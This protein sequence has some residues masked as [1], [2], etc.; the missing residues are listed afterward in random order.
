[1][2]RLGEN[3]F[4]KLNIKW[5]ENSDICLFHATFHGV[6]LRL[7]TWHVNLLSLLINRNRKSEKMYS[8]YAFF[9]WTLQ[10]KLQPTGHLYYTWLST[11]FIFVTTKQLTIVDIGFHCKIPEKPNFGP[12][13]STI[14]ATLHEAHLETYNAFSFQA[15][16]PLN[17]IS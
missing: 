11:G 13:Q 12:H 17:K 14:N 1:M 9:T 3:S 7:R 4:G 2:A 15:N 6:S 16:I 5:C 10:M 8:F